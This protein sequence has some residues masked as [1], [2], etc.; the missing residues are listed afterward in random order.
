ME[1]RDSSMQTPQDSVGLTIVG[2]RP[3]ED[4]SG[5]RGTPRGLEVLLKKASVDAEFRA[6]LPEKRSR[7]S[8]AIALKLDPAEGTMLDGMP[9]EQLEA[10]VRRTHV[11]EE[12]RRVFLGKVASVMLAAL[13]AGVSGCKERGQKPERTKGI[14]PDRVEKT[15]TKRPE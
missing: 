8:E 14:R 6:L 5:P 10:I 7:A 13:G 2:G 1:T 11:P 15:P 12:D 4:G 9:G 3:S